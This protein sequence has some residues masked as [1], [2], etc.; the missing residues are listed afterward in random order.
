M[1]QAHCKHNGRVRGNRVLGH[2]GTPPSVGTVYTQTCGSI[3]GGRLGG[4]LAHRAE[5]GLDAV[6]DL[7]EQEAREGNSGLSVNRRDAVA[8]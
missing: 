4:W 3:G 5:L 6:W 8:R 7:R 2:A 1:P